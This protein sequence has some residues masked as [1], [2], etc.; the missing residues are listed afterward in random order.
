M[1]DRY[2]ANRAGNVKKL[3]PLLIG[4]RPRSGDDRVFFDPKHQD[5]IEIGGVRN[6]G[7][8]S[9]RGRRPTRIYFT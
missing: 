3:K 2:L 8:L 9:L 4:I 6:P 7:S 1:P 5:R